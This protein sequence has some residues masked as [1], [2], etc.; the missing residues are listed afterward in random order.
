MLWL[1]NGIK[2]QICF[3]NLKMKKWKKVKFSKYFSILLGY[4]K[5]VKNFDF[6]IYLGPYPYERFKVWKELSNYISEEV[7]DKIEPVDKSIYS[8]TKELNKEERNTLKQKEEIKKMKEM[9]EMKE[10]E[11]ENLDE[12]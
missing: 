4:V 10:M 1:G 9:K 6:D 2:N 8:K 5:G 11:E 12:M 7:L 3:V